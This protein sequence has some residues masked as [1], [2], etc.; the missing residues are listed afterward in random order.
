MKI[1]IVGGGPVGLFCA[2]A[3][4]K[5]DH[6][7]TLFEKKELPVAKA[8]GEGV[9]YLGRILLDQYKIP[10][11]QYSTIEF[12]NFYFNDRTLVNPLGDF[13]GMG[14]KRQELVLSLLE[15]VKTKENIKIKQESFDNTQKEKFDFVIWANGVHNNELQKTLDYNRIGM[16]QH[17]NSDKTLNEVQVYFGDIGE[18]YTTPVSENEFQISMILFQDKMKKKLS[19]DE[20][21]EYFPALTKNHN[22][23]KP[24]GDL[25]GAGGFGSEN[26]NPSDQTSTSLGDARIFWDGIS[27][28]G[29]SLGFYHAHLLKEELKGQSFNSVSFEK[30]LRASTGHYKMFCRLMLFVS[31]RKWMKVLMFYLYPRFLTRKM[32]LA[33]LIR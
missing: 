26:L 33:S 13:F 25:R 11:K 6:E 9:L 29:L 31:S 27:G 30:K 1:A 4:A 7:I 14:M 22:L 2:Q 21:L 8:C 24:V 20:A 10:Y 16:R 12:I 23:S 15:V 17:Y 28:E 5:D 19:F 32:V 18:A 3:L